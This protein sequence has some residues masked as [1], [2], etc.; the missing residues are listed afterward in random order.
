L[1]FPFTYF[2]VAGFTNALNLIDGID[3]LAGGVA[4]I[5]LGTFFALFSII[6][7]AN[8]NYWLGRQLKVLE[9]RGSN[10]KCYSCSFIFNICFYIFSSNRRV[11]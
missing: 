10:D 5:I 8:E 3:G 11:N 7:M 6:C 9:L 1:I 2:A 4:F